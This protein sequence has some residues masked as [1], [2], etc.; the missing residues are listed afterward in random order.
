METSL[1]EPLHKDVPPRQQLLLTVMFQRKPLLKP[2]KLD[3]EYPSQFL[4]LV[5]QSQQFKDQ[6]EAKFHLQ[7]LLPASPLR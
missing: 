1:I 5:F 4:F 2:L 3:A 6:I 7:Q